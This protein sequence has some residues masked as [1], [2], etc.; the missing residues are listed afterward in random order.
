MEDI[1]I[2]KKGDRE[3]QWIGR[4]FS[5]KKIIINKSGNQL[6]KFLRVKIIDA[7]PTALIGWPLREESL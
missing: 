7:V 5:Y 1:L 2:S 4:N 3:G 6:G